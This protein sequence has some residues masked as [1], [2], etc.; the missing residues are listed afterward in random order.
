MTFTTST[1]RDALTYLPRQ[2]SSEPTRGSLLDE[3]VRDGAREMLAAALEA[4]VAAYVEAHAD[5]L[6]GNG[7]R[8]VVRNGHH[9]PRDVTTAADA[10]GVHAPRVNDKRVDEADQEPAREG[11]Q[12]IYRMFFQLLDAGHSPLDGLITHRFPATQAR[13]AHD[14]VTARSGETLGVVVTW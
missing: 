5:Q 14:L 13:T 12:R 8:L 6:D 11:D 7:H 1:P 4:D 9:E 2:A 10:I 3:M